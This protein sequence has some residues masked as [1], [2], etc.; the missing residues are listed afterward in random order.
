[1]RQCIGTI[2]VDTGRLMEVG[3]YLFSL[4]RTIIRG[5]GKMTMIF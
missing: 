2:S 3:I 5:G 1:M 4:Q